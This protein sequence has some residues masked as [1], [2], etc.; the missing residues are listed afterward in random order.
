ML[1]FMPLGQNELVDWVIRE[2]EKRGSRMDRTAAEA[3]IAANGVQ[4]TS[5]AVEVDKLCL[6]AG[7]G[8]LID[9]AVVEQLVARSTEQN[10]FAMVEHI[11]GL[12]L[13]KALSI[14]YE[15]LKQ[16]EE[17][18]KI[19]A[20]I[21]RQF[22]IMLQVQDLARQSYSQQQIASQLGLHP[23]A[24]KIAGEQARKFDSAKLKR[25]LDDLAQLD[26]KMKS[27]GIDKVLGLELFLLK[28]G[29]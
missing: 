27:G 28:L 22:R 14:F 7:E 4:M 8:G 10:V 3:L 6:Y 26:Y 11:A 19:A 16:K 29:A 15:L 12:K 25:I 18:I 21:A 1:S 24:V 9:S 20:L 23:Y 2:V 5:L 17:P 13:D